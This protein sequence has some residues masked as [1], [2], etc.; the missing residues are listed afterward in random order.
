MTRSGKPKSVPDR[1]VAAGRAMQTGHLGGCP[2]IVI[3]V[4]PRKPTVFAF[5]QGRDRH[6]PA[7]RQF[8]PVEGL[9]GKQGQTIIQGHQRDLSDIAPSTDRTR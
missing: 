5:P 3:E 8:L 7:G 2:A 4:E 1:L 6:P 9:P